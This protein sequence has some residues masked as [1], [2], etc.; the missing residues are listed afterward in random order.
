[1]GDLTQI[2]KAIQ[3]TNYSDAEQRVKAFITGESSEGTIESEDVQIA[4]VEKHVELVTFYWSLIKAYNQE[5][6]QSTM[7]RDMG[8]VL[9]IRLSE[10][11]VPI[12][13]QH[14]YLG[15][16]VDTM[17]LKLMEYGNN[18]QLSQFG[19]VSLQEIRITE[20]LFNHFGKSNPELLMLLH[21]MKVHIEN[22]KNNTEFAYDRKKVKKE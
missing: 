2:E 8:C 1:M 15:H 21:P 10:K 6:V 19:K 18:G 5:K 13:T 20:V 7:P 9:G 22:T 12:L 4:G 17:D 16:P 11:V 14:F 3:Y